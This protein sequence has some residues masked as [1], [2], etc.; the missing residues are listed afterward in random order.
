MAKSAENFLAH[1]GVMGMHWGQHKAIAPVKIGSTGGSRKLANLSLSEV[2]A[3]KS[4]KLGRAASS[5]AIATFSTWTMARVAK[6]PK[7]KLGFDAATIVLAGTS[8]ALGAG[9]K[10]AEANGK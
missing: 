2:R 3:S 1:H 10:R 9:Q 7:V 6:N 5:T 4:V 8:L